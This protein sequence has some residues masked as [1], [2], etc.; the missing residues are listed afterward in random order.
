MTFTAVVA[1]AVARCRTGIGAHR[2]SRWIAEPFT[3]ILTIRSP[4]AVI[5]VRAFAAVVAVAVA[6]RLTVIETGHPKTESALFDVL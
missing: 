6:R 3:A 4:I 2:I 1:A 5:V